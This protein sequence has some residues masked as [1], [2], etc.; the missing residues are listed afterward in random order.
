MLRD[1]PETRNSDVLLCLALWRQHFP[2]RIL[3]GKDKNEYV[4]LKDI[5]DLPREDE[6]ARA[7]RKVQESGKYLPTDERIA[8]ARRLNMDEWRVAM[9][10]PT[11]DTA[12]T[13]TPSWTPPSE[14]VKEQTLL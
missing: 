12:G 7:R 3:V 2:S 14:R 10:Y 9:G 6:V 5:I 4:K 13:A 8:K 1:V 11:R